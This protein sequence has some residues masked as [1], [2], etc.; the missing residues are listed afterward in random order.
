MNA[1]RRLIEHAPMAAAAAVLALAASGPAAAQT[2]VTDKWITVVLPT[3]PPNLEGC[4]SNQEAMGRVVKYNVVET[5][6]QKNPADGSLKP[7]LATSWEQSKADPRVWTIKLRDGVSFHD[8]SPLNGETV[9]KSLDRTMS[10]GLVCG[11]RTKFFGDVLIDVKAIDEHTV[12]ITSSRPEPVLPMRLVGIAIVGPNTPADKILAEGVGPVGTGPY[13]FDSWQSGQQILLKRND[14]YWG[15]KP[16]ADGARYVWRDVSSVRASMVAIGEADIALTIA[17]QEATNPK[18]DYSYLNSETT[19]LRID[20]NQAPLNDLRVRRALNYAIDRN[21]IVGTVM[22][23]AVIPATQIV[24][25]SIPGHNHELD[26]HQFPYDPAKAK[27]LLAKAKA[28]GVPVDKEI[29]FITYPPGYPNTP[30]LMDALFTMYRAVGFNMK[31]QTVDV[32][33][34]RKWSSKPQPE[35]PPPTI[36]QS[37]SDNSFGD[38]VFNVFHR[39]ACEGVSA[40]YCNP[41]LDK[42]ILRVSD[43]GGQERIAGWQGIFRTIYEDLSPVVFLYHMVGFTRVNPRIDFVPDVSTNSEVRIEEMHFTK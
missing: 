26:K 24:M 43:L 21:A 37:T 3:E 13:V 32:A 14:K 6:I 42:D 36:L 33:Q 16:Q 8:G 20:T 23:K 4:H 22:P 19:F 1:Y 18:T 40:I 11:N 7:R 27:Q 34:Y 12:Q 39:F 31:I 9:K 10:K 5:L 25:P 30:E 29:T 35:N 28:D 41:D 2:K 38:P 17:E 15:A